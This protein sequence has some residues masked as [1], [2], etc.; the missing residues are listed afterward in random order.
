LL[1]KLVVHVIATDVNIVCSLNLLFCPFLCEIDNH[2]WKVNHRIVDANGNS[3]LFFFF[4]ISFYVIM[5]TMLLDSPLLQ[6][7][8]ARTVLWD[9]VHF[10]LQ[11][12]LITVRIQNHSWMLTTVAQGVMKL[13]VVATCGKIWGDLIVVGP[14]ARWVETLVDVGA[15]LTAEV[16]MITPR[17][18]GVT[19][20]IG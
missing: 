11:H 14:G 6:Y 13:A 4:P 2:N 7:L 8:I 16:L 19:N 17:R 9:I 5:M 20:Y 15:Q 1:G 3:N 18:E 12:W 10:V